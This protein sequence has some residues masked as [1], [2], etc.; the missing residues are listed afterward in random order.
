M[1][2]RAVLLL[3][4]L[5]VGAAAAGCGKPSAPAPVSVGLVTSTDGLGDRSFNDAAYAGLEACSKQLGTQLSVEQ[6]KSAA[7]YEPRLTVL[8]TRNTGEVFALGYAMNRAV[9]NVARRFEKRHFVII[10]AVV[11]L[12]NVESITF[13]EQDGSFLAGALAALVSKT[14][15][16]AF[17]GGVDV[18]LTRK[19][20]AGFTAG[21]REIDPK[22]HVAV[23]YAGSFDDAAA[24]SRAATTLFAR[25][26]DVIYT[27]A[28]RTGLGAIAVAKARP[29]RYVI[30]VDSNQDALAP[31]TVLASVVKRVD[32]AAQRACADAVAQ[33]PISGHVVLG[34]ADQGVALTDFHFTRRVV[35][36]A[37]LA[38]LDRLTSAIAGGAIVPPATRAEVASFKPVRVAGIPAARVTTVT[39][40]HVPRT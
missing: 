23:D 27:V 18:P 4:V 24:G 38:Y 11:D 25:G 5:A 28:G 3:A 16:V 32:I 36:A 31:G 19:S 34:V 12:P 22:I 2:H 6:P 15:T 17:I 21:V 37:N 1:A 20:E 13:K 9:S 26:A 39:V 40:R 8:A 29:G 7:D 10:D 30:G 33:K 35:G 14:K